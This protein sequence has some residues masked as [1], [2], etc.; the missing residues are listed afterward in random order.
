MTKELVRLQQFRINIGDSMSEKPKVRV[1]RK[2]VAET[3]NN[4]ST[5]RFK[6]KSTPEKKPQPQSTPTPASVKVEPLDLSAF[7]EDAFDLSMDDVFMEAVTRRYR[8]G[9]QVQGTICGIQSD[10]VLV[11][12]NSKSEATLPVEEPNSFTIGDQVEA[13][14]VRMDSRGILLAQ[15]IGKSADMSA[16]E[17]AYAEQVPVEGSVLSSNKGGFAIS[18]GSTKGFCPISQMTLGAV[19]AEEHVGQ[20]YAFLITEIKSNELIVSRR[21]LIEQ[22]RESKK[23]TRLAELSPGMNLLGTILNITQHGAFVDLDGVDGLIPK[24]IFADISEDLSAGDEIEVQIKA[25]RDGKISLSAPSSNPWLKMGT[26]FLRGGTYTARITKEKEFGFFAKLAPNLEG[27]LHRSNLSTEEIKD[28]S[29]NKE[30]TVRI[31]DFDMAKKRIELQLSS[32]DTTFENAPAKTLGDAFSDVFAQFG[33]DN[34]EPVKRTI[35]K[36]RKK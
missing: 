14:I 33:F 21:R 16:Y 4:D 5:P 11:D 19:T 9:D 22:E 18:F 12:I 13:K 34:A 23:E 35:R 7:E 2:V 27:L 20:T 25:I 24:F 28:L 10:A 32:G 6:R 29:L 31:Q 8:V 15:K 1:R 17:M 3:D 26:E 30:V 36:K